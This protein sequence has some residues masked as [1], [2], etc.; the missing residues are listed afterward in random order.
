MGYPVC[1]GHQ[2]DQNYL[3][4]LDGTF[5]KLQDAQVKAGIIKSY[6]VL[7]TLDDDQQTWKAIRDL[8]V[9]TPNASR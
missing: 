3:A 8:T 9:P 5:K 1:E 2:Q 7:R 6:K 4:Y